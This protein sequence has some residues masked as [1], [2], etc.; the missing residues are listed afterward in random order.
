M[1]YPFVSVII[2]CYNEQATIGGLLEALAAQTYPLERIE[3]II[4]DGLSSDDTRLRIDAF[5]REKAQPQ[6][7]VVDN[8]QRIIPAALNRALE[9]ARGEI[10]VR[11]DAHS[12]PAADY[13]GRCVDALQAAGGELVGGR[14]DIHPGSPS[15]IARSISAAAANPIGVGNA[16][17]R[18]SDIPGEVDTV[19]FGAYYRSLTERIGIYDESL[20]TNEDYEFAFRL[21]RSGGRVW[22]D[23]AI[24]CRYYARSTL[25][26]LWR[27][28]WRYG[29]WKVRMLR[30]FPGS[31]RPR[32]LAAPLLVVGL[33][34]T[35][36]T[37][38]FSPLARAL[39]VLE[40]TFY[41]LLLFGAGFYSGLKYRD[42]ALI[43][44]V[45]LAV[46]VMHL[47]WGSA[48]LWSWLKR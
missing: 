18:Y 29:F 25:G 31:L 15:W 37:A 45:P 5:C 26:S 7:R 48:F 47:A 4:A 16:R 13:I 35:A 22:F 12:V 40:L 19:P 44:G 3:V 21:R 43:P 42:G 27:Q 39:F 34:L 1:T 36:A 41:A 33:A 9:S 28:Y 20:Q 46:A 11:L 32:Q 17:Y 8:P 24:H 10:I 2:P 23:P 14:W 30:K 38:L 6:V